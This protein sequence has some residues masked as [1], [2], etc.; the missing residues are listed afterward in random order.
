MLENQGFLVQQR[1]E[2]GT[3]VADAIAYALGGPNNDQQS[4]TLGLEHSKA[5]EIEASKK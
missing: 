4:I 1:D 3:A 5:C 2:C